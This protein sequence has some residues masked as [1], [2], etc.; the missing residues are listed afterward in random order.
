WSRKKKEAEE[1]G[2]ASAD[3]EIASLEQVREQLQADV[4][5]LQRWKAELREWKTKLGN[6]VKETET[7]EQDRALLLTEM[8][9]KKSASESA[10]A[11]L[12]EKLASIPEEMRSLA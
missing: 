9:D 12:A 3:K 1:H 5:T 6:L 10:K 7:A 11:V 2:I 8:N 4:Q